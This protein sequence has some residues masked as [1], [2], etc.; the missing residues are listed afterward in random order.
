MT[1]LKM[2]GG[3]ISAVPTYFLNKQEIKAKAKEREDE[4]K[5]VLHERNLELI[6]QGRIADAKWN[7]SHINNAGWRDEFI[8][9]VLSIPMIMCFI[10]GLDGY[11][12]AGFAALA[13]TPVWYQGAVSVMIAATF[14]MKKFADWRMAQLEV[15]HSKRVQGV[16]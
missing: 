14:G 1:W 4:M 3:I 11:V 9:I 5:S 10:P 15:E 8:T 12:M 16:K 2:L 7:E 6:K 13:E